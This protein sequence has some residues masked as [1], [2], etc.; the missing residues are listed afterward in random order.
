M[1][2]VVA[3]EGVAEG[4]EG[5]AAMVEEEDTAAVEEVSLCAWF[6]CSSI[7]SLT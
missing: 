1:A 3:A 2:D 4:A 6:S 5:A 7:N